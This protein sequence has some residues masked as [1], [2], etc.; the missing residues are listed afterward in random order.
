VTSPFEDHR[1]LIERYLAGECTPAE[2]D[3]VTQLVVATPGLGDDLAALR[4]AAAIHTDAVDPAVI[5]QAAITHSIRRRE[6]AD[7][8]RHV[9]VR[10]ILPLN[11]GVTT[12]GWAW[13][14]GAAIAGMAVVIAARMHPSN[15]SA[16]TQTYATH[17]GEQATLTIADG[18]RVTLAPGTTLRLVRFGAQSRT[19]ELDGEAYFDVAHAS[20]APFL[21]RSGA[22]TTRVLGTAFLMRHYAGDRAVRVAVADGKVYVMS[23]AL[24]QDGVTLSAGSIGDATDSTIHVSTVDGIAPQTEWVRGRLVF[25]HTPVAIVLETLSRWYGY[26]FHCQDSTLAK[27][28]VT[29]GVSVQSSASALSTLEQTLG[30][31]IAVAGDTVTLTPHPTRELKGSSRMQSYDVWT[32]KREAGR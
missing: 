4:A 1:A 12:R 2:I 9:R 30:V 26:Q 29:I 6:K 15:D 19:V 32:P 13:A 10:R 17:T 3:Q 27:Q 11:M 22:V 16:I 25:Y 23:A 5:A 18:T 28:N 8:G 24:H 14:A 31:N 21:V 20:G 7:H